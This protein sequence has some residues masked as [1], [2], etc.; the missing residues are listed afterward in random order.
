MRAGADGGRSPYLFVSYARVDHPRV[1]GIVDVLQAAG[2]STW[3]D[4]HDI[5]GGSNYGHEIGAG[6]RGCAALA[7]LCSAGA[8]TSPNVRQEILLAWKYQRPYLPLLLDTTP[9]PTDLEYWLEGSQWI[10]ILDHPP[11]RW[12]PQVLQAIERLQP[13][14]RVTEP[15]P[16]AAP[17]PVT[18]ARPAHNLPATAPLI[19]R[20]EAVATVAEYVRSGVSRIVT[21]TGPGGTGKTRLG[22]RV[23]RDL[24]D[25]FEEVVYVPLA[26]ISDARLVLATIARAFEGSD[27]DGQSPAETIIER[28][29]N[30][31]VLLVLDNFEH[32]VAAAVDVSRIVDRC[33][34]LRVLVTSRIRLGLY[35]EQE[36]P[37]APLALP[38]AAASLSLDQ[39]GNVEAIALFAQRA[40][41][42]KP[43]F[44]VTAQNAAAVAEICRR[45]DGLPLAIELAA[46][47]SK[48]LTPQA[49]VTRM[50]KLLP[51]LTGGARDLPARQ[52][53][54]RGAIA[55]SYDLLTPDEQRL[56]RQLSV[57]RGGWTLEAAEAVA[58]PAADGDDLDVLLVIERLIEHNLVRQHEDA[59]GELRFDMLATIREFGYERLEADGEATAVEARHARYI[60]ALAT[61][62]ESRQ[63][64]PEAKRW[65]DRLE[66][67]HNNLRAAIEW[68]LAHDPTAG[69]QL[70]LSLFRYWYVRGYLAEPCRWLEAMLERVD[71]LDPAT[72]SRALRQ[73]GSFLS[74]QDRPDEARRALEQAV[75]RGREANAPDVL[76]HALNNHAGAAFQRGDFETAR[77]AWVEALAIHRTRGGDVDLGR[78]LANLSN[79]DNEV[80]NYHEAATHAEEAIAFARRGRNELVLLYALSSAG[81][82]Y[83]SV[84]EVLRA[85]PLFTEALVRNQRLGDRL[86]IL[87][88]LEDVV[89]V[90]TAVGPPETAARVAGATHAARLRVGSRRSFDDLVHAYE[91]TLARQ[92]GE[93]RWQ[94]LWTAGQSLSVEEASAEALEVI[95][96]IGVDGAS[97]QR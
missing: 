92:L 70:V 58:G 89:G 38:S 33:P 88:T 85:A 11:A 7:L 77:A 3:L 8:F 87:D 54:L 64:G 69:L 96:L 52:Q 91:T 66:G 15:A 2:V 61:D 81:M 46:A 63:D 83:L 73:L 27:A 19:G 44:R 21:L 47:R 34:D 67:E 29:A 95:A 72:H 93:E 94:E 17:A 80:G 23:A 74:M 42:L 65:L 37:V 26:P 82:A 68:Y 62:A 18:L 14:G 16:S 32:V 84:G 97:Q 36:Y 4:Q 31:R 41:A 75:A 51:L 43:D 56:Y 9:I 48:V 6:I 57:F 39:L 35:G 1:A 50:E 55:W 12:L 53:T 59:S 78:L 22:I 28:C 20:V 30:R 90:I 25:A 71:Q 60:T 5:A 49:M 13:I 76:V 24:V 86:T 79:L 10:E 45:L 40:R